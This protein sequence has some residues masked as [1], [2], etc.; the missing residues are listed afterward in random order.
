MG[1]IQ[2]MEKKLVN[3]MVCRSSNFKLSKTYNSTIF[4]PIWY[5]L[6]STQNDFCKTS[7]S[8]KGL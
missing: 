3:Y 7:C 8:S 1:N 4:W 2:K 6:H 5:I